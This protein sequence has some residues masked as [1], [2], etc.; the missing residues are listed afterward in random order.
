MSDERRTRSQGAGGPGGP[1]LRD[2]A[3]AAEGP[4]GRASAAST[5][6]IAALPREPPTRTREDGD[7]DERGLSTLLRRSLKGALAAWVRQHASRG[8]RLRPQDEATH[9]W[10]GHRHYAEDYT[11]VAVQPDLAAVM[12]VEWLPGREGHRLWMILL[13]ADAIHALPGS[14][15]QILRSASERG[16]GPWSVGG[17]TLDCAEPFRQWT[18]A[19]HGALGERTPLGEPRLGDLVDGAEGPAQVLRECRVDLT[20]I[21]DAPAFVPGSD[22]DPELVARHLGAAHWD[23]ELLRGLRR[24]APRGYVQTGELHGTIAL[25]DRIL[26]IS[27]AGLRQHT[28]G[29]RDW[30]ASDR[31][32]H[33]FVAQGPGQRLWIHRARFPWLTLEGG[34]VRAGAGGAVAPIR[35]LGVTVERHPGRAPSRVS[36]DLEVEGGAVT[37]DA[38]ALSQLSLEMDGRGRLDLAFLRVAGDPRGVGLWVGQER[39]LPRPG[40]SR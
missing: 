27:A 4:R 23:A 12:R 38:E 11:F 13:E 19:F 8:S 37:V 31:A 14:G 7:D 9:T 3:G 26:A 39:L 30:G 6:A 25:G 21:A 29:Q 10:D 24:R 28:W 2:P 15:Q 32:L 5:G 22:D 34:F 20:F 17:F 1:D 16:E 36:L 40:G 18:L 33:C 35:E